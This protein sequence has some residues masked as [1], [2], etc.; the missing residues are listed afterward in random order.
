MRILY[1]NALKIYMYKLLCSGQCGNSC[2]DTTISQQ[3]SFMKPV[4]FLFCFF[5]NLKM[6]QLSG[7][8]AVKPKATQTRSTIGGLLASMT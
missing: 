7:K 4:F 2:C 8:C 1:L 3:T 6:N 5:M